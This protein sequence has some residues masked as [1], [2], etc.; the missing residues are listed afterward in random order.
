RSQTLPSEK[1]FDLALE[2]RKNSDVYNPSRFGQGCLLA[3]RL[4]EAGARYVEVTTEYIP[5]R[6]WDCHQ[7]GHQRLVMMKKIIDAPVAQ[8]ILDL[9]ERGLLKRDRKSTRLNSSH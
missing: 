1:A 8:L 6:Y 7:D 5:F 3:R 4:V 2:P 9:E